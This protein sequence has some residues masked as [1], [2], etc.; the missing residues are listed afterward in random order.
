MT[1]TATRARSAGSADAED[2]EIGAIERVTSAIIHGIR[3]GQLVPGQHLVEA[4][5]TRRYGISRGS[6]REALK[7]MAAQGIVT[8]NRHRGA[9]IAELDRKGV[10][11]LLD[12]LEPLCRL[13]ARLA[14]QHC[15]TPEQRARLRRI[16]GALAECASGGE[17]AAY[18]EH[19]RQFYDALVEIGG[20]AELGRVI[21][22]SRT[23]LFRAQFEGAQTNRQRARHASGYRAIAEAVIANDAR[24]AEL[25]VKRHFE[26]TRKTLD[27]LPSTTFP[28]D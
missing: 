21:P 23:D 11:D 19:R 14:A 20:N 12:T 10:R 16:A 28:G 26:G 15:A 13:A 4:D 25:A 2:G 3:A 1:S 17:R 9:Y 5:L 6:L 7:Q 8:L 24:A 18:L 27:E 22:L